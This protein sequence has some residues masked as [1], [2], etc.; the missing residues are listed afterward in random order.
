MSDT[1]LPSIHFQDPKHIAA[2]KEVASENPQQ[3]TKTDNQSELEPLYIDA[4]PDPLD[5]EPDPKYI[6]P[7]LRF[8]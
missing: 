6:L 8:Y 4:A 3:P 5:E 2:P 7:F 1:S